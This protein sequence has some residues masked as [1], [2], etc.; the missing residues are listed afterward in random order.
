ME[1]QP[2]LAAHHVLISGHSNVR[3][4][5]LHCWAH[6]LYNLGFPNWY[7][8]ELIGISGATVQAF[9]AWAHHIISFM[10]ELIIMDIAGN[11]LT[12]PGMNILDTAADQLVH[13]QKILDHIPHNMHPRVGILEQHHRNHIHGPSLNYFTY[14]W[15]LASWHNCVALLFRMDPRIGFQ[16]LIGWNGSDWF[17]ELSDGVHLTLEAQMAYFCTIP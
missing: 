12:D 17:R 14:N 4:L 5:G 8:I 15:I 9:E 2:P 6:G 13:I 3:Q 11:D 16:R 7:F 10:L 1:S